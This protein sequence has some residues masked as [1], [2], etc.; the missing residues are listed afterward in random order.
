[1][2]VGIEKIDNHEGRTVRALL[3]SGATGLFMSKG[4]VQKGRYQLIKLNRPLQVRNIDSTGNSRGAITHEVEVNMFYKGHVERVRMDVYEL[5]KTDMILGMLWLAAH[6]PEIDWEKGEVRM[7]RCPPLCGKAVKIKGK[8]EAREDEKKIVRWAVDEKEDWGREEEMEMDHRK[9]EEMVPKRFHKWLKVF[10]KVESERMLVRKAWD[11]AIDLND[12]F[13]VSKAR[14]YPLSRNEKEEVQKFVDEHLKK[15]Y[16]RPSKLPQMSPVFFVS[17]KDGGK[18]M[19]MDYRRLNK[20]TVKNNYPL[21]LITDLVDSMGNKRV[22][23]KM[24]LQW[25]YN[26]V[27]IKEG[28]EWKVAFTTH[29]GSYEP[30]VMFFGIT[31][32]PATFQGMMNEILRDMI[33]EG[34]VAAFVDDVLIGMETEEGHDELVEEVLKRLEENDLYVKP[35]KCA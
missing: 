35:E 17:K 2:T 1:M 7:T 19:V 34:K 28:D 23:T 33:N 9:I 22:F 5:G 11:H 12:D 27:R 32:S 8:K 13:K 24:N 16:I 18:C 31:N 20:Q 25:G 30:V 14:V 26:N 4:L 3:D 10:R 21:P 15:G 29:V 6:N